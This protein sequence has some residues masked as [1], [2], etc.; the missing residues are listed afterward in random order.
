MTNFTVLCQ[1]PSRDADHPEDNLAEFKKEVPVL[2]ILGIPHFIHRGNPFT[3]DGDIRLVCRYLKAYQEGK[4]I[5]MQRTFASVTWV[6][7]LCV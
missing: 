1:V 6:C 3:I 7:M 2:G 4:E 5:T